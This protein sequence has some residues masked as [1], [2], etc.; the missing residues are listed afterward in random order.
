VQGLANKAI[1]FPEGSEIIAVKSLILEWD[2]SIPIFISAIVVPIG[3]VIVEVTVGVPVEEI[4]N[5]KSV[6]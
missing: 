5:G 3:I 6:G 4:V 1:I 2:K